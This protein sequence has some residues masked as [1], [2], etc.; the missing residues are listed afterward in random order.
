MHSFNPNALK[1][2]G[3]EFMAILGHT[4]RQIFEMITKQAKI[5][6]GSMLFHIIC[7]LRFLEIHETFVIRK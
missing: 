6:V 7:H 3:F 1:A 5:T 2:E 4:M